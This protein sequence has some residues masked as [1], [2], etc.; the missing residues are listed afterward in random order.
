MTDDVD[1]ID[2]CPILPEDEAQENKSVMVERGR[3]LKKPSCK[4]VRLLSVS[5]TEARRTKSALAI[6][7]GIR[8]TANTLLQL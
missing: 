8:S 7:S 1:F 2:N 3:T 5:E 4:K 6:F